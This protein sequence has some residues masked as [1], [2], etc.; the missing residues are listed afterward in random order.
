MNVDTSRFTLYEIAFIQRDES[1]MQRQVDALRGNPLEP[2]LLLFKAQG[3]CALGRLQNARQ[4]FAQAANIAQS[5]G[6]KEFAGVLPTLGAA[7]DA[8]LGNIAAAR[9]EVSEALTASNDRATRDIAAMV[10]ARTGDI[11]RAQKLVEEL[12]NEF[13]T[14]TLL[15]H[16]D[17]PTTQALIAIQR[18]S[19]EK[20]IAL[21][22]AA[23][24]YELGAGPGAISYGPAY[25]RGEAFL[26]AGDG[27]K[28]SFEYQKILNHQGVD[29]TS[30]FYTM[31]GL[32]LGRAYALQG[33][34]TK[35]KTAYQDFFALW[36][37]ADPD[38]PILKEA[39]AE[40][41]KLK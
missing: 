34:T 23:R 20:A 18:N 11:G 5:H 39:K 6:M 8:E 22:E 10:L 13:P 30:P 19:P 7:C 25:I 9:Q 4:T 38:I 17:I 1:A 12:A 24:A 35:A 2:I 41:A 3:E 21:L 27:A 36:K 33:E 40:Y 29:P 31:A 15:N 37:D 16:A 26:K 14:D 28:A 32:G